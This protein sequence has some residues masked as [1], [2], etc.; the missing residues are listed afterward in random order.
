MVLDLDKPPFTVVEMKKK[1]TRNLGTKRGKRERLLEVKYSL[2]LVS[3]YLHHKCPSSTTTFTKA[4]ISHVAVDRASSTILHRQL[5]SFI[6]LCA[7]R[8]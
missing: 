7:E 6:F 2:Y 8:S 1:N 4:R 5:I 3:V